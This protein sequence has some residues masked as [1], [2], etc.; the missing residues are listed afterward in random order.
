MT[1]NLHAAFDLEKASDTVSDDILLER[2][3]HYGIRNISNDWFRPYLSKRIRFVSISGF[4]YDYKN[5]KYGVLQGAV[6]GP[7][8]FLAFINYLNIAIKNSETSFC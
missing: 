2:L 4:N 1:D 6:L 7:L 8:P 3:N 5:V